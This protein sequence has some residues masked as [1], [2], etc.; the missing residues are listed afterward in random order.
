MNSKTFI[1][2]DGSLGSESLTS[3]NGQQRFGTTIYET[4]PRTQTHRHANSLP[5]H[6]AGDGQKPNA[7]HPL[8]T[9]GVP[10]D[11][12]DQ[13]TCSQES[14]ELEA[15]PEGQVEP[16]YGDQRPLSAQ[17]LYNAGCSNTP[18]RRAATQNPLSETEEQAAGLDEPWLE[19]QFGQIVN[20]GV[21][22]LALGTIDAI[23]SAY[24]LRI[25]AAIEAQWND[26]CQEWLKGQENAQKQRLEAELGDRFKQEWRL[27]QAPLCQQELEDQLEDFY[28]RHHELKG[29]EAKRRWEEQDGPA[30][31]EKKRRQMHHQVVVELRQELERGVVA[32]LK[33]EHMDRLREEARREVQSEMMEQMRQQ[34]RQ[35]IREQDALEKKKN[36]RSDEELRSKYPSGVMGKGFFHSETPW[37]T[38]YSQT[39]GFPRSTQLFGSSD[40][41]S[42]TAGNENQ[43]TGCP[44]TE[45]P[46]LLPPFEDNRQRR[47]QISD[48]ERMPPPPRRTEQRPPLKMRSTRLVSL[49][50]LTGDQSPD[51]VVPFQE[52]DSD[53]VRGPTLGSPVLLEALE[54][55][56]ARIHAG[57]DASGAQV[58]GQGKEE[59]QT[60]PVP[61]TRSVPSQQAGKKRA[62]SR[63]DEIGCEDAGEDK[64]NQNDRSKKA[65]SKRPRLAPRNEN[66]TIVSRTRVSTRRA[67]AA[68]ADAKSSTTAMTTSAAQPATTAGPPSSR[69][70]RSSSNPSNKPGSRAATKKQGPEAKELDSDTVDD[71]ASPPPAKRTRQALSRNGA[72]ITTCSSSTDAAGPSTSTTTNTIA[73]KQGKRKPGRPKG[74]G[75]A[76][77][78]AAKKTIMLVDAPPSPVPPLPD[79]GKIP[80]SLESRSASQ[81]VPQDDDSAAKG[82]YNETHV[83]KQNKGEGREESRSPSPRLGAQ[84]EIILQEETTENA[85]WDRRDRRPVHD[86]VSRHTALVNATAASRALLEV[87]GGAEGASGTMDDEHQPAVGDDRGEEKGGGKKRMN[88]GE[89]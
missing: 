12:G 78:T 46:S 87:T 69:P 33:A 56:Q 14:G 76:P 71:S 13:A 5:L 6:A 55:A 20:D 42:E 11:N 60:V 34:A 36:K 22:Q 74:K 43:L 50:R 2:P 64:G 35:E 66:E 45:S 40:R 80:D 24:E 25:R 83:P 30:F 67:A 19:H 53:T 39:G 44:S 4:I 23:R 57:N 68:E 77:R 28:R 29:K 10:D 38:T 65:A 70:S 58:H 63:E 7:P 86:E 1:S 82:S 85:I 62:R 18:D 9:G 54:A 17:D 21:R 47:T 16:P 8:N 31:Y 61:Q 88:N 75:K 84:A 49:A 26:R 37:Q 3:D 48:R 52:A 27:K 81:D 89:G 51:R 59:R 32:A 15:S 73:T 79:L 41:S 72:M